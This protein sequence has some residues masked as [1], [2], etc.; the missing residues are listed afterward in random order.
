VPVEYV[1]R[2]CDQCA[3]KLEYIKEKKLWRCLYCGAEVE[4]TEQYDGLFTIKNVV[5]QVLLDVAYRRLDSAEKNMVEC[6]KIDSRYIGTIIAKIACEMIMAITPG[7]YPQ[8][9]LRNL[10]SQMK[11]HYEALCAID[12]NIS[13]EEEALYEFFDSADVYATLLLVYDSLNDA[14]RRDYVAKLLNAGEVYAKE[15]NKNL[16]GYALKNANY[17]LVDGIMGNPDNVES[18]FALGELLKK[19]PDNENKLRLLE[20][21]FKSQSFKPEDK[22]TLEGYL[23]DSSDALATKGGIVILGHSANVKAGLEAVIAHV[24][25]RA[26]LGTVQAVLGQA[27]ASRLSDEDIYRV[28]EFS[29]NASQADIAIAAL[30]ALKESGQ[31][32]TMAPRHIIALLSRTDLPAADKT[33]VLKAMLGFNLDAKTKDAVISNYLCFNGD[34]GEMRLAVLPILFDTVSVI[35][36]STIEHYVMNTNSDG[37]GKPDVV[38]QIFSLGLNMSFFNDLLAK[39]LG[40]SAD[41]AE[42]K[43]E[44]VAAL[45]DKGLKTDANAFSGYICHSTD[46][47]ADKANIVQKLLLGGIQMRADTVNTYLESLAPEQFDPDLFALILATASGVSERALS[48]Y[49]LHCPDRATQKAKNFA[50]L[51]KQCHK[52]IADLRSEAVCCGQ[53]ISGSMLPIYVLA[54]T[55]TF[56]VAKEIIDTFIGS[57]AKLNADISTSGMGTVKLKKFISANQGGISPVTS[58]ICAAYRI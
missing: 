52:G 17:A 43:A 31:Y 50:F 9:E 29:A 54:T 4:R 36:T 26:D 1:A 2:K 56:G 18:S 28:I 58:Q 14:A 5:R 21:L 27:C 11:R 47:A 51:A 19:Y 57:K 38:R 53:T 39:Y 48:N 12:R 45:L 33:A 41:A 49:L 40:S 34:V 15:P 20:G 7:A 55:D 13:D 44:I 25:A 10:F 23:A 6:E 35:Q 3:G 42:V 37:A 32:V 46:A 8:A 16:L 22:A 30:G 24:L